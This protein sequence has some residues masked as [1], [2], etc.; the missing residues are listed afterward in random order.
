VSPLLRLRIRKRT[1]EQTFDHAKNRSVYADAQRQDGDRGETG[2]FCQRA[3]ALT[4]VLQQ[5]IH[6]V[7]PQLQR[8]CGNFVAAV[9]L[10][11]HSQTRSSAILFQV[12]L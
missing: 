8:L 6:A 4:E 1:E 9:C 10:A 3:E 7:I 11:H 2:I 5:I 12:G